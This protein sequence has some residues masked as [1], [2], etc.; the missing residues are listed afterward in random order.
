MT[1]DGNSIA[2]DTSFGVINP[3]TGAV[4]AQAPE[5]SRGQLDA[6][7]AAVAKSVKLGDGLQADTQLGPLNNKMHFD[8]VN[9]RTSQASSSSAPHG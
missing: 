4:F 3:A 5:R 8:R 2:G 6:A 9:E 7:I 1:I